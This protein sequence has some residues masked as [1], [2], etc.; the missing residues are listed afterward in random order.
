MVVEQAEH[1]EATPGRTVLRARALALVAVAVE[2]TRQGQEEPEARGGSLAA[3]A[4]AEAVERLPAAR[5]AREDVAKCVSGTRNHGA[6]TY[7]SVKMRA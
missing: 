1:S 6:L 3:E 2:A 4:A 7:F 5:A